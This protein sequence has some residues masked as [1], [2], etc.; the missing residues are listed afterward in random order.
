MPPPRTGLRRAGR[1]LAALWA[2]ALAL[3]PAPL[4]AQSFAVP[5]GLRASIAGLRESLAAGSA[6]TRGCFEEH[7]RDALAL[8]RER[9]PLYSRASGGESEA[10][11]RRLIGLEELSRVAAKWHDWR[12]AKFRKAGIPLL[13]DEFSSM[14][15]APA[16]ATGAVPPP[17]LRPAAWD[18]AQAG[19]E[20][21]GLVGGCEDAGC[22]ARA[23][24]RVTELIAQ[25]APQRDYFCMTRHVLESIRRSFDLAPAH[26]A[27][28]RAKGRGSTFGISRGFVRTQTLGLAAALDLD[29]RARLL[30]ER[31]IPILCGDLPP[32][33]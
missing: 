22:F 19:R 16:F 29:E 11:S 25:V 18:P 15:A 28:A 3:A 6:G 7:I 14:S 33:P 27:A 9:L 31:G 20:I 2:A 24:R 17:P 32:I 5:E 8:N 23:S 4:A 12:A 26:D 10:V 30:Q 1:S 13:C 21:R